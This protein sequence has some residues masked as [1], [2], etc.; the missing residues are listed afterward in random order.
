MSCFRLQIK[1]WIFAAFIFLSFQATA[2]FSGFFFDKTLRLDYYHSGND[3]S[4]FYTFDELL[5]EPYWGGSHTNLIDTFYYGNYYV[6]VFNVKNDSLLY[7]RGYSSLFREWQ[8]TPEAKKIYRTFSE[9]VTV[10]YPKEN[11]RIEL[12]S[13]NRDGIFIKKFSYLFDTADYF[14]KK[15][16]RKKY[17]VFDVLINGKP[18]EKVDIVILPE[19]Y[20]REETGLFINDCEKFVKDFFT[21]EPYSKNKDKFNIR[22]VLAPSNQK[23]TDIPKENIWK[24]TILNTSYYTFDS[25]RY[26]M[27][28]DDKSVR[29]LAANAPYDQIYILVNSKKYGGGAI[30]NY[31]NVSVNS[32]EQSAKILIHEFGHGFAGLADEYYNDE[33]S[34]GEFYNLNIEPWEPN[35]TTL[36]NFDKKWKH[37]VKKNTPIPTPATKKYRRK[38]GAFEGGG[39]EPKGMYRPMQDCLMKTFKGN[40]FCPACTEAIQKMIDFYCKPEN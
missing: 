27:T 17:P 15:D 40:K 9:T 33:T 4:E 11:V 22:A 30:Y 7:S 5:E 20:T 24:S 19:G 31:Y 13:R 14:V 18:S 32:N 8:T 1:R 3:T 16:M 10:P 36:K 6:K 28:M 21:F 35:I 23:G 25:E 34:Y 2:Q 26:L 37:L 39:Y 38:V 29:D 12:Y